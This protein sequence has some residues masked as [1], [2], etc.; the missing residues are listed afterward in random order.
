[1]DKKGV[2]AFRKVKEI[3][4]MK[5]QKKEIKLI[6]EY[7]TGMQ[8]KENGIY[9][10][11]VCEPK[12]LNELRIDVKNEEVFDQDEDSF[13]ETGRKDIHIVGSHRALEELGKYFI[14]LSNYQTD[15]P[16]YHDHFE[17]IPNSNND[18]YVNIIPHLKQGTNKV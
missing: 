3:E 16:D 8:D 2:R 4:P 7:V 13:I 10:G 11:G 12:F 5:K 9:E 18:S 14:A 17:S 15:D 1:M 6:L